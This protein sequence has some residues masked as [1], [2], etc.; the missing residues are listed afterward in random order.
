MATT[1]THQ[2]IARQQ[3]RFDNRSLGVD[4]LAIYRNVSGH[5]P[6]SRRTNA[7]RRPHGVSDAMIFV[8]DRNAQNLVLKGQHLLLKGQHLL[9]NGQHL[10]LNGQHLLTEFADR[11]F[12]RLGLRF[13]V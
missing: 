13:A 2:C 7:G 4:R 1:V 8:L 9:L 6:E 10:L 12:C 11:A 5:D 3:Q